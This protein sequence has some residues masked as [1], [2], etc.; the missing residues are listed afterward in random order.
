M[1]H[2]RYDVSYRRKAF[3][4]K[5]NPE[6]LPL[7]PLEYILDR[8]ASV[9]HGD[10]GDR[11]AIV[12]KDERVPFA[13][14]AVVRLAVYVP[15]GINQYGQLR[16]ALRQFEEHIALYPFALPVDITLR[17]IEADGP[18]C[19]SEGCESRTVDWVRT[20]P[21][22][23]NERYFCDEHA[24]WQ[25][26]FGGNAATRPDNFMYVRQHPLGAHVNT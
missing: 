18:K 22:A 4:T 13:D 23:G 24:Q 11:W 7:E 6:G 2:V 25:S 12:R 21:Y 5:P 8:A 20:T 10:S 14:E 16:E 17:T 19:E 15:A 26:D 3:G 1:M 9:I